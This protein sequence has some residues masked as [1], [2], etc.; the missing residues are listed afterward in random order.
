MVL[1]YGTPQRKLTV[2]NDRLRKV[3]FG[4]DELTNDCKVVL[5]HDSRRVE[6]T[7][8][9]SLSTGTWCKSACYYLRCRCRISRYFFNGSVYWIATR[10]GIDTKD[11]HFIFSFDIG[12][13]GSLSVIFVKS[14]FGGANHS[15]WKRDGSGAWPLIYQLDGILYND[16]IMKVVPLSMS[17]DYL[18][19]FR[20]GGF[21]VCD[22]ATHVQPL[23]FVEFCLLR[24]D[25]VDNIETYSL[26]KG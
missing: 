14:G 7:F 26:S 2:P 6:E 22:L 15:I 13:E 18:L 20:R 25:D 21:Y 8:V 12:S 24:G 19:G 9:Y 3:G 4:F 23:R 1:S 5:I 16:P 11:R 17:D 10:V